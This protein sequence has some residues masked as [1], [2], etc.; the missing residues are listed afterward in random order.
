MKRSMYDT[1]VKIST[2][3]VAEL[4]VLFECM[5]KVMLLRGRIRLLKFDSASFQER[6]EIFTPG[7]K[8]RY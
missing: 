5:E 8:W 1:S 4:T 6:K 7:Q 3:L 2:V